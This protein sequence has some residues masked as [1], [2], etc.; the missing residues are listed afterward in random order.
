MQGRGRGIS[1]SDLPSLFLCVF[2][3]HFWESFIVFLSPSWD[4]FL[5]DFHAQNNPN[6]ASV[7]SVIN[8][9]IVLSESVFYIMLSHSD[10]EVCLIYES[11]V[12]EWPDHC[13]IQTS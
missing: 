1:S 8:S 3:K 6:A 13:E 11:A 10:V 2:L 7:M 12:L 9:C 5:P 4:I